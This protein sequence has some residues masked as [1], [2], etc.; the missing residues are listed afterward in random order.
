[1]RWTARDVR[2]LGIGFAY[3]LASFVL[4]AVFVFIPLGRTMYLSLFN[5]RATG[6][7]STFAGLDQYFELFTSPVFR[8]GLV[9]TGLFA[10][11][12]VPASIGFGLLLAVMRSPEPEVERCHA[13]RLRSGSR[14][15]SGDDRVGPPGPSTSQ[16][17]LDDAVAE[18]NA[19]ID[20]Y[21]KAKK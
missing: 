3:L 13:R 1:M 6:A 11:Y 7:I 12:T 19:Q 16:K 10:L 18:M 14:A 2:S 5:T 9:A 17:A 4:F 21:N 8:S 20:T 15:H